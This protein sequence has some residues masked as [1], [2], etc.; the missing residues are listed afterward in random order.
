MKPTTTARAVIGVIAL[1][2]TLA[3]AGCEEDDPSDPVTP[4]G[5]PIPSHSSEPTDPRTP[6]ETGPAEPSS[7]A[8]AE[9]DTKQAVEV[10]VSY[11]FDVINY[12]TSTGDV[13][14]LS[15]LDQPSCNGCQGGIEFV[16]RVYE[17][18]GRIIGGRYRLLG[19][20][21]VKSP[22]GHWTVIVRTELDDQ[23]VVGAGKLNRTYPGGRAKWLVGITRFRD[24]WSVTM[25][26]IL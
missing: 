10:F 6:T 16:E 8:D 25:L 1:L 19:L 12:A 2:L 22:S 9:S 23:R 26:D 21:P 11:Y 24:A 17:H 13:G 18:G 5:K 4:S 20:A 14:L 7:P 3:V 15:T